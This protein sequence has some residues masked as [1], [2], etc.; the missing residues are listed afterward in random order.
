[1]TTKSKN[2]SDNQSDNQMSDLIAALALQDTFIT[3]NAPILGLETQTFGDVTLDNY[4]FN[5]HQ[6]F[7]A[8]F[9]NIT[10]A[11]GLIRKAVV[12]RSEAAKSFISQYRYSR[13]TLSGGEF[14]DKIGLSAKSFR[15][16]KLIQTPVEIPALK[17][18]F[19]VTEPSYLVQTLAKNAINQNY[20]AQPKIPTIDD[21]LPAYPSLATLAVDGVTLTIRAKNLVHAAIKTVEGLDAFFIAASKLLPAD[22]VRLSSQT[23]YF[24]E[25]GS[26]ESYSSM[27]KNTFAKLLGADLTG[28]DVY[29]AVNLVTPA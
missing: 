25:A 19:A 20:S 18:F 6:D 5:S 10:D 4:A 12:A 8:Q 28:W 26:A 21:L 17:T 16:D 15:E 23:V 27:P 9:Y 29:V 3:T 24:K 13:I 7:A 1:M 14:I 22:T 11:T 2:Q